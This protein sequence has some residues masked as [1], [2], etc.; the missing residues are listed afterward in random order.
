[1]LQ[2]DEQL[3]VEASFPLS[4]WEELR[5]FVEG[6]EKDPLGLFLLSSDTWDAWRYAE[7]GRPTEAEA[8]RYRFGHLRSWFK[9]Y[10]K[11]YS[12]LDLIGRGDTL[13]TGKAMLPYRLAP[14]DRFIVE[15]G[16]KSLDD[17]AP[18][19]N[20]EALWESLLRIPKAQDEDIVDKEQ[21]QH[22]LGPLH[23]SAVVLQ[24]QTLPFWRFLQLRFG[25]PIS[26][27]P[28]SP[29]RKRTPSE[30]GFDKKEL[31]PDAVIRQLVNKLALHRDGLSVLNRYHHLRLCVLLLHICLG[32][33][34]QE[35]LSTPRGVGPEGPLERFPYNSKD[36]ES[37]ESLWFNFCPNKGG[38]SNHV[39]ISH[40]WEDLAIYC[41]HNLIRYGDEVRQFAAPEEKELLILVAPW[42]LTWGYFANAS[43]V[44]EE[45]LDFTR[46]GGVK[47]GYQKRDLAR[48][49]GTTALSYGSFRSWLSGKENQKNPEKSSIGILEQW[50]ITVDGLADSSVYRMH[51]HQARHTRQSTLALDPNIP[52]VTRQRDMNHRDP[53][54]QFAYHHIIEEKNHEIILLVTESPLRG[55]PMRFLN[56]ILGIKVGSEEIE[57]GEELTSYE[58][59]LVTLITPRL[60]KLIERNPMY[61]ERNYVSL[62][63]CAEAELCDEYK[64]RNMGKTTNSGAI[65]PKTVSKEPVR[66]SS[67]KTAKVTQPEEVSSSKIV[68]K[69]KA[70]RKKLERA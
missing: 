13:R 14:A 55:K 64:K 60:Q 34:I 10:V 2:P 40:A 37:R 61:F 57:G 51:S 46:Q 68:E 36:E 65:S 4:H 28:V 33:R 8:Y 17:L 23:A 30:I 21:D 22:T 41:I 43:P 9:L 16:Y 18:T 25:S 32:R 52:F 48:I 35:V 5:R 47:G 20:F 49:K 58:L 11:L 70:R 29:H 45:G 44:N 56:E 62:G 54:M 1:M 63:L 3:L 15:H 50:G 38:P 59:N 24:T 67:R 66:N 6:E 31:I 42:N 12:Y 27:L 7:N 39:Y 69:L 26:L 19:S 53:N